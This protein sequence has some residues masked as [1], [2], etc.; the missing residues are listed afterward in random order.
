MNEGGGV[1]PPGAVA[2]IG[3]SGR[4]PG[5][6]NSSQLWT[7]V[8]ESV[9]AITF[10]TDAQLLA[11]GVPPEIVNAPAYVKA[12]GRLPDIDLFDASFFGMSPRD[13]AVFDPQHRF[14]LECAWEA[15]EDAGY[16]GEQFEGP[17]GVYASS[18]APE[19]FMHNLLR[20][21]QTMQS[22]GAWLVR[23]NG[24][25]PNFLATRVSYELNLTGPS[26]SVQAACSSSLL[27]VHI[28]CQ[29]L[30]TGECDM[31]LAG[32]STI[33]VEQNHGYFYKQGEILSPDGHC[34]AFDAKA[35]GTVMASAVGCVVLRRLEDAIRDGDRILAI[36]RGSAANND[37]SQKVGYLA[38]S[39]SG[40][41]R[42]VTEALAVAGVHPE[43]VS[44]IEAHGTGTLIGDPIEIT[45]LTE[46]FRA[47]TEKKQ[48]CAIGSIKSNIG[49]AGEAAGICGLIKTVLA[50]QHRE[51]PPSL[52]F[53]TPNPQVDFANS[54]FYVNATLREWTTP[55]G[56]PRIAG[57]TGLGAGG[58]NVHVLLE[59]APAPPTPT[60]SAR[61]YQL[62]A[63]SA[64]TPHAL[65][66][67]TQDL[68]AYLRAH[69][70]VALGDVAYSLLAGRK[71]FPHRR[72]VVVRDVPDA[73]AA[74]DAPDRKRFLTH[75]QKDQ[76]TPP[77]FF[78]FPGGGTQYAGM[79]AEL[80]DREPVYRDAFEAALAQ[81]EPS[82]RSELR[83]LGLARGAAAAAASERLEVP[84]RAVSLLFVTEYAIARLLASWSIE[85][86]AMIG[87]SAGEYAV[88]CLA[89]VLSLRDAAALASLRGRLFDTLPE[90][91]MLSVQLPAEEARAIAGPDVSLAAVNGPSLCVLSGP[92][93]AIAAAES[94]L[95]ARGVEC[96]R[97]HIRVAAHSSM[98]DRILPEFERFCRTVSFRPPQIPFVSS[99][100]GTWISD[101]EAVD[102]GYWVQHL[103]RTVQFADGLTTFLESGEVALCEVG[104]GRALSSFARQQAGKFAAVTPTVRHPQEEGS[105][106]A[107]L[108]GAVGRLWTAGVRL[109]VAR[110]FA[111]DARRRESLPTYPFERQRFWIDPDPRDTVRDSPEGLHKRADIGEWFSAPSWGRSAPPPRTV[112]AGSTWLVFADGSPL[113]DAVLAG[114]R[115][116]G[117]SVV[118]V[119]PAPR[120]GQ[121]GDLRYGVNPGVR[122]HFDELA[123]HLRERDIRPAGLLHLWATAPRRRRGG[124]VHRGQ[125]D[126][127]GT[128]A[129]GLAL[130]YYSVIFAIQSFADSADALRLVCV[131]SHMQ[132]VP[133]DIEM[134]PE[135]AVLLGPC[136]VIPR[137]YPHVRCTSIDVTGPAAGSE[138][139]LAER[140][141]RELDGEATDPEIALRGTDR[142]IRRFDQI[143]L[144]STQE[145]PWLREGGVYLLTGGLGG[146][147]LQIAEH[148]ASHAHV[149]LALVGRTALPDER[150]F[151]EWLASHPPQDET[152][153]RIRSVLAIRA[154]GADVMTLDADVSDPASMRTVLARVH[155]R[156]GPVR[157]VFHA[158]GTLKDEIIALRAPVA[159]SV[160]LDSK[161]KGALVLDS[162]LAGEPLDFFVLFSS[163]A[164]ILGLPGQADYTAAN[165]FL[166][167]L[168]HA[169][170]GRGAGR[171]LTINWNAWQ[172]VGMLATYVRRLN[173][174]HGQAPRSSGQAGRPGTHPALH[175]VIA[176]TP[177]GTVFRT[178]FRREGSWLLS[179]HVVRGGDA[180]ISG[181]GM[182]EI[183]RAALDYRHE[184]RSVELRDVFF[185]EPFRV[186]SGAERTM[187]V[188]ID[189]GGEGGFTVYGEDEKNTFVVGKA[190]YVD[191]PPASRVDIDTIR[192]RC[193]GRGQVENGQLV[194]HFMDFGPRWGSA[195]QI[196]L[197]DR[198]ALV[199][200]ELPA[201]F[202]N[203]LEHYRLHPALLDLATG[204]AQAIVPG[205]DPH[206]TFYVPFS[207]GR[208][209]LRRSMP[210][211]VFSHIRLREPGG[212]DSV[213]FDATVFDEHGEVIAAIENFVMR[214][215]E[216]NSVYEGG[217]TAAHAHAARPGKR[218]ETPSEAALREGM[219]PAEGLNAL[220]RMLFVDCSPQVVACT[221]P[222]QPWLDRLDHEAR[223]SLGSGAEDESGPVFTRPSVSATFA[224]P[225][226][227]V[228]REIASL[229][230]GLLGVSEVGVN[231]DFFE[232]GGQSLVA[233]RLFQRIEK[234]YGVDLP[235][236]TLFQ[237]PTI[238]ECATLLRDRLG[239]PQ[240]GDA[241][242]SAAAPADSTANQVRAEPRTSALV[243][244][245][246]GG[247][248]L[249][250]YCVHGAGGNV[251]NF[252]D[253]ARAMHP[254]QPF[255]GL[256]AAGADG[257][258]PPHA[259]IEEMAE[260]Y[261]AEIRGFQP[262]GPYLLGGYSGGG[263]VAFE[264]A[265]R[266]TERGEEV[267][268]LVFLD[269]F[270]P[271]MEVSDI[272]LFS[273]LERLHLEGLSYLKKALERQRQSVQVARD[274]RAIEGHLARGEAIPFNLRELYLW[275]NFER[276]QTQYRPRPWKGGATLFRAEELNPAFRGGGPTY[277]WNRHVLGGVNV[278]TVPGDH[279]SLLLGTNAELL[280][281]SLSEAIDRVSRMRPD[282]AGAA[283]SGV[284]E[285][286]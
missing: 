207:Y 88:A 89:G 275:R 181:T 107:F 208:I 120:F 202:V 105:D 96:T 216:A 56:K 171:T 183:A 258:S 229:W 192:A 77:V 81:L 29:S 139:Q 17:V 143:R 173:E 18:G 87:H 228:E 251:L 249:P 131:S 19:Y 241:E 63:L 10:F 102:P 53:E 79:G 149:K 182:L 280:V 125:W 115:R 265:C 34:R 93:A 255:Y 61:G 74:L 145:R 237:A 285:P 167:A 267:G 264:M 242:P 78:M 49:H 36:I 198:E 112:A 199:S 65:D 119:I 58:T 126:P 245:Q 91:G 12:C 42:V 20:N 14:F 95:R 47:S 67:V 189:R 135:K 57:V 184:P 159:E 121:L 46:A 223:V 111:G 176:D 161:M 238:A 175:E 201:A 205:F 225:R 206:G 48:F 100:T 240:P 165:A 4:F 260:A 217:R 252:R 274:D 224:P 80:Y 279:S 211:N 141:L 7:N 72:V 75:H 204:G 273:R 203:D 222:L 172:D 38:P 236:S 98:I 60:P 83:D 133:G 82:L 43:D 163:V 52:H 85:P 218:P 144:A 137:E 269:T 22:V 250:F 33:Y 158:A 104:P 174:Q 9:E 151:E 164:S 256:Q 215:V 130:H 5:A 271:Q 113:S 244:V 11:A 84:S 253:L 266:L 59:E 92:T 246:R 272:T 122:A 8:R 220:D 169:R 94:A 21:R 276:A 196:A 200:L 156:F 235:L 140:L 282:L 219:T 195:R 262:R 227:D 286:G 146:I 134:H 157:G 278:V 136:K 101:A 153:R 270:H 28:A 185:L 214:Q 90:G 177:S 193:T 233:V 232:L 128:Y 283:R 248:R 86:A 62:L 221:L 15:F 142:W 127:I 110:L 180:L 212:K 1:I 170:A 231:D 148:I 129:E 166:D 103:R 6:R 71:R 64:R 194:Q 268:L 124:L 23:H 257:V 259:T 178:S 160:V 27:A 109:D 188:R 97:V 191:V 213:I 138:P 230:K 31:A 114:L 123:R 116:A 3:L 39:V 226:D 162:V 106:V 50:L 186:V 281:R 76:Q 2:V 37:G 118:T 210:A 243:A 99:V 45:A 54:P 25:D 68:A 190:H 70:D 152:S 51:I 66:G 234:K 284:G 254:E 132:W 179:E 117:H 30:A 26:M 187:H 150:R 197:G 32:G 55:E 168:A 261:L 13:A 16:V 155:E 147:A 209:L 108:L 247:D 24:N 263:I 277:G 40:Q 44:Y 35:A 73:L 41:T 69:S 239:L 154:R